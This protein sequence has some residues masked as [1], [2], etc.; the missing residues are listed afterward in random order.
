V[1]CELLSSTRSRAFDFS[2]LDGKAEV[3]LEPAVCVEDV[4]ELVV[5]VQVHE[6]T[7]GAPGTLR[8]VAYAAAPTREQ[9]E[10]WYPG[11]V[12]LSSQSLEHTSA[13]TLL[14]NVI[15]HPLPTHVQVRLLAGG[16]APTPMSATLTVMLEG[17]R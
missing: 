5:V 8:V 16:A 1:T 14:R 15:A 11:L 12:E 4:R 13:G 3:V 2:T 6:A 10:V 9:P 17:T 7:I